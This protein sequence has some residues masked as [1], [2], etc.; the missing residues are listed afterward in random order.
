MGLLYLYLLP[1]HYG[2]DTGKGKFH[3]ITG[4]KSLDGSRNI[5]LL[6]L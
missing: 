2:K 1:V 6:F 4:Y 3:A 5:S